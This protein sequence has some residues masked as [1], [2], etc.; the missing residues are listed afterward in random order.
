MTGPLPIK[1]VRD[2]LLVTLPEGAWHDVRQPSGD[3]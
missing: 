1:G 3:D 2:G